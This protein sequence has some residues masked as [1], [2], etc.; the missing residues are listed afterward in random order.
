MPGPV[1][2]GARH[3]S[4]AGSGG[5]CPQGLIPARPGVR[6]AELRAHSA[7]GAGEAARAGADQREEHR[8][9]VTYGVRTPSS[10]ERFVNSGPRPAGG[11][12]VLQPSPLATQLLCFL[13]FLLFSST[14]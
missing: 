11:L 10:D 7:G 1:G 14:C 6:E 12:P 4:G 8:E 3:S 13:Y 9:S 5:S 2:R